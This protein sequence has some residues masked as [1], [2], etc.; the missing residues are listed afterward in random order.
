MRFLAAAALAFLA[1]LPARAEDKVDVKVNVKKG[2]KF[3]RTV[4]IKGEG[5]CRLEI[6]DSGVAF[7]MKASIGNNVK[8]AEEDQDVK[9][10]VPV[11]IHR[12]YPTRRSTLNLGMAGSQ[13]KPHPLEGADLTCKGGVWAVV[14]GGQAEDAAKV[15]AAEKAGDPLT[16]AISSG[17]KSMTVGNTWD[18]DKDKVLTWIASEFPGFAGSEA[19]MECKL[20]EFKDKDGHKCARIEIN[21]KVKGKISLDNA[22]ESEITITVKG[23]A[24]YATDSGIVT[25]L[26]AEGRIKADL[27][28]KGDQAGKMKLDIPLEWNVSVK[29][30]EADFEAAKPVDKPKPVKPESY[31]PPVR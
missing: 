26:K 15:I 11:T 22:P 10:G 28:M 20:G 14:A 17:G 2:L 16:D 1:A 8:Q 3:T 6:G 9:D 4:E 7:M 25:L 5:D 29:T 21:A 30:G 12:A 24:Y 23:D 31:P 18:A 19:E 27:E 13:E